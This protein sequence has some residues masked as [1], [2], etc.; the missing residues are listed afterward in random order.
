M[1]SSCMELW[2]DDLDNLVE[3]SQDQMRA[4]VRQYCQLHVDRR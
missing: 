3:Q 4:V 2:K 1:R